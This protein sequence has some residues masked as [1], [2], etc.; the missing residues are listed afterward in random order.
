MDASAA[1]AAAAGAASTEKDGKPESGDGATAA[2]ALSPAE[3]F[4]NL[5]NDAF[6][7]KKY[8]EAIELYSKAIALDPQNPVYYSN[9]SACNFSK[10]QYQD[11]LTDAMMCIDKD[12][13]FI[14][15]YLR[16]A[17]A[18]M[19][20]GLFEDAE[21]TLRAALT[22]EPGNDLIPRKIKELKTKRSI[23]TTVSKKPMKQLSEDQR[24]ELFDLQEQASAY[25]RDLRGV[26]NRLLSLD[27][28]MRTTQVTGKQ[29]RDFDQAVPMYKS[30]GK[31]YILSDR[32]SI[33]GSLDK[34]LDLLQKNQQ[35]LTDRRVYLERRISSS[36]ANIR[37]L[38]SV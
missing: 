8:D 15:G 3:T 25:H 22:L 31:A 2:A 7:A 27:R 26:Q 10:K 14:K 4:K 1:T 38:Q 23:A 28:E 35:D 19:E 5:G 37:D 20:L 9:R 13:K 21:V 29:I 12:S 33:E 34:E 18:Q 32:A 36:T 24:K 30:V 11:A 16:L 6:Q 17:S